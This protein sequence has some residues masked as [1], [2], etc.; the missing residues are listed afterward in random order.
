MNT[1][2]TLCT[3]CDWKL[4]T[5]AWLFSCVENQTRLPEKIIL[6]VYIQQTLEQ[7]NAFVADMHQH[8]PILQDRLEIVSSTN[9]SHQPWNYHGYDRQF[10][11]E[12]S[13]VIS[14]FGSINDTSFWTWFRISWSSNQW[15]NIQYLTLMLDIDNEVESNFVTSLLEEYQILKQQAKKEI[16]LAPTVMWRRTSRIQSQGIQWYSFLLPKYRYGSFTV[17]QSP[18]QA[19]MMGA[20]CLFGPSHVFQQI[21]FDPEFALSYEDIDFTYRLTQSWIPLYVTANTVTYH[22]ESERSK[23]DQKL[24]GNPISAY[25]RMKNYILFVKKNAAWWQKV[26]AFVFSIWGLYAWFILN[27]LMYGGKKRWE[28][29]QAL[30]RGLWDGLLSITQDVAKEQKQ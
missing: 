3:A 26:Q 16:L 19:M 1:H 25:Y 2:I 14:S 9:S 18:Q 12:Q 7:F 6:L 15:E 21:W 8:Y 30:S 20:N 27:V 28:S 11:V 4:S 22:M 23:L 5:V 10:L 24:I 13:A 29:V 17:E